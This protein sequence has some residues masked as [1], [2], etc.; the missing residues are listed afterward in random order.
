VAFVTDR[1]C[2]AV[3]RGVEQQGGERVV[4]R[5]TNLFRPCN[6]ESIHILR[7]PPGN[8]A[9]SALTETVMYGDKPGKHLA[10]RTDR[11]RWL[12]WGG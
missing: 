12:L 7:I 4:H 2:V 9:E 8:T 10:R 3:R 1:N 11:R 5:L 6:E